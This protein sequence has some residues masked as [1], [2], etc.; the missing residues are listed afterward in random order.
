MGADMSEFELDEGAKGHLDV[1]YKEE[2]LLEI[3]NRSLKGFT[4]ILIG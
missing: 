2:T 4:D 1:V 3:F